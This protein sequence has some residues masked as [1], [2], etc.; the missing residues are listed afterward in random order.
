MVHSELPGARLLLAGFGAYRDTLEELW[1]VFCA[2]ELDRAREI[3]DLGWQLEG[4]ERA[5]LRILSEFL[6][7]PPVEWVEAAASAQP[8]VSFP[9]RL[10]HSEVAEVLAASDAM[11]V[12]STF[13]E[14]FGMVAAEAAAAGA[15][16]VCAD[17]SGLAEVAAALDA[18]LPAAARGLTAFPL[19]PGAIEGI[20][21]RL[22]H[23][24]R[25]RARRAGRG[26]PCAAGDGRAALELAGGGALGPR[27]LRRRARRAR[28]DP[29][30]RTERARAIPH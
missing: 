28:S 22:D 13:P 2:G 26:G 24:V 18:E 23:L 29:G 15:L 16:P 25:S 30:V 5:P 12:P 3:A 9:G 27:R 8:T 19:G 6:R 7:E 17:H 20:A 14:A 1:A 21:A 10:E 11:V 4:G